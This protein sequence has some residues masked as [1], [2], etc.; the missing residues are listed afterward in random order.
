MTS[1]PPSRLR[2]ATKTFLD[3][4]G[5]LVLGTAIAL[6]WANLDRDS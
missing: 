1:P 4:S 3:H 5:L 6:L 2:R